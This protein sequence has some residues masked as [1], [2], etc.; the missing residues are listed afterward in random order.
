[1]VLGTGTARARTLLADRS[2]MEIAGTTCTIRAIQDRSTSPAGPRM[3]S[4]AAERRN[5]RSHCSDLVKAT[6]VEA[7]DRPKQPS[8]WEL[9]QLVEERCGVKARWLIRQA[10]EELTGEGQLSLFPQPRTTRLTRDYIMSLLNSEDLDLALRGTAA[11]GK[12]VE[13]TIDALVLG[14]RRYRGSKAFS[15]M[16]D[17]MANFRDYAPFNN[18]LVRLQGIPPAVFLRPQPTGR[19]ASTES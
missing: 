9:V 4:P 17:F 5:G 8:E 2:V 6:V 11:P 19:D 15:E 16:L 12:T 1:M 13:S 7:I 10:L 3:N 18:M 14:A